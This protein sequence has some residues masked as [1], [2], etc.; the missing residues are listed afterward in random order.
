MCFSSY[1]ALSGNQLQSNLSGNT[2][3]TKSPGN[4]T[5]VALYTTMRAASFPI[6]ATASFEL[7]RTTPP[8]GGVVLLENYR[9]GKLSA[10]CD[11]SVNFFFRSCHGFFHRLHVSHSGAELTE[12]NRFDSAIFL[13]S[14]NHYALLGRS[15]KQVGMSRGKILGGQSIG[16]GFHGGNGPAILYDKGILDCLLYTSPSP[17][18]S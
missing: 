16:S 1:R 10:F 12:Q 5:T 6:F 15:V 13:W 7:S 18:D 11:L 9:L 4:T 8:C 3:L 14:R 2:Q 17:R